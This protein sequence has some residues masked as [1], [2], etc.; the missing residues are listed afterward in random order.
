MLTGAP[1]DV[2]SLVTL[3]LPASTNFEFKFIR[4][5]GNTV[6]W[7]QDPNRQ[8]TTPASGSYTVNQTWR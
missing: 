1:S 7:E 6:T 3:S 4:K 5:N 2:F 8:S